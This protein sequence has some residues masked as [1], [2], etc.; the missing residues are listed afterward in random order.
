MFAAV[1]VNWD[2]NTRFIRCNW[3]LNYGNRFRHI[4]RCRLMRFRVEV[5][6]SWQFL[7]KWDNK[8]LQHKLKSTI[9]VEFK[10]FPV[11]AKVFRLKRRGPRYD[12]PFYL[13][14]VHPLNSMDRIPFVYLLNI[15]IDW[16]IAEYFRAFKSKYRIYC[17]IF[18][19]L[20]EFSDRYDGA[21]W[22]FVVT[23]NG[24]TYHIIFN[25]CNARMQ[26]TPDIRFDL[27][28][29]PFTRSMRSHQWQLANETSWIVQR[30]CR[31][32]LQCGG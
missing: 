32:I 1:K 8:K 17:S 6:V 25:S 9:C 4:K 21:R 28:V 3:Q 24:A 30:R 10:K 23:G 12:F 29:V 20:I 22:I 31:W 18:L 15:M 27:P 19:Y 2:N 16:I 7:W 26:R 5:Q 13:K 14:S 11:C